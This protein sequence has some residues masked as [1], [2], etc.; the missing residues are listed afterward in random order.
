MGLMVNELYT[1]TLKHGK[2]NGL[3][4]IQIIIQ[5]SNDDQS[6]FLSYRDN[7]IGFP[8]SKNITDKGFGMGFIFSIAESYRG[9]VNYYNMD[10]AVIE[11]KLII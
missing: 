2:I 6:I 4:F 3:V 5:K 9:E 1:N 10:G 7:G 8:G 11:A